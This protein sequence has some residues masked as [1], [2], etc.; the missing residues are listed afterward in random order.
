MGSAPA[1]LANQQLEIA[2]YMELQRRIFDIFRYVSCHEN[3]FNT[4]SIILE[5]VL[6]DAGSFFDSECQTLIRHLATN[7]HKFA[8]QN[9]IKDFGRKVEA[10]DNFNFGDYRMLL[11]A[12]FKISSMVVN[13][14]PYEDAYF[15][16]PTQYSP[17]KVSGYVVSPFSDWAK[18]DTPSFWW[19]AFTDLK[20]DRL[21]NFRNA[22]LGA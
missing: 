17:D 3:N 14:N 8:G 10:K 22:T 9:N 4:Y 7:G 18:A 12:H 21:S 1:P 5:S 19:K 13:L 11:E 6:V 2:Y 15:G 20:H 16:N